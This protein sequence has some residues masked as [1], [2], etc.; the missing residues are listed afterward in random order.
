MASS[1]AVVLGSFALPKN[2]R[3]L[4]G[5]GPASP[6]SLRARA[7]SP[8]KIEHVVVLMQENRSFDQ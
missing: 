8:S 3:K 6:G 4:L 7:G 2:L 1:G 5:T